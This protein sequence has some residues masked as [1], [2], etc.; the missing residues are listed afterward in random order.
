MQW[1]CNEYRAITTPLLGIG[2]GLLGTSQHIA[3][4]AIDDMHLRH[5]YADREI[6]RAPR[7]CDVERGKIAAHAV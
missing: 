2:E 5:A 7:E 3:A 6:Q 1:R 4:P